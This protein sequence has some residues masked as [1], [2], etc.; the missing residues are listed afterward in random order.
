MTDDF[1]PANQLLP[2]TE[3][4]VLKLHGYHP[5]APPNPEQATHVRTLCINAVYGL[6]YCHKPITLRNIFLRV[7]DVIREMRGMGV[8]PYPR[9]E[10]SKR[11]VDRRVNEAADPRFAED[12]V[13]KVVCVTA[14][15]YAVNP[16]LIAED[17]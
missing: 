8:W 12:G 9:W 7:K 16:E 15:V 3:Q 14:G 4:G 10:P 1:T 11:Y 6:H 2:H 13:P 17:P 5:Q